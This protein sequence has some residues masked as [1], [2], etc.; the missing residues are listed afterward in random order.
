MEIKRLSP[1]NQK[2]HELSSVWPAQLLNK[3]EPLQVLGY[4]GR[5][6]VV[7]ARK[8]TGEI[9]AV[10]IPYSRRSDVS[11]TVLKKI[12][13][14]EGEVLSSISHRGVVKLIE[15][16]A[17]G[18]YIIIERLSH[19]SLFSKY[20]SKMPTIS[21]GLHYAALLAEALHAVHV[22]GYLHLDFKP[23]N[24]L[25]HDVSA[26][27]PMLVDFGSARHTA[28]PVGRGTVDINK[29]GTGK[30]KF[31]APEQLMYMENVYSAQTDGFGLGVT[32]Y[33]LFC[34]RMPFSNSCAS[35]DRALEIYLKEYH[36]AVKTARAMP[37]PSI[38]KRLVEQLISIDM[39]KRPCNMDRVAGELRRS[40][41]VTQAL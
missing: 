17:D 32:L 15:R 22:A 13:A 27:C 20:S 18:E 5:S 19:V 14:H 24:I 40:A 25:F 8:C 4:G 3:Y 7:E 10:K 29:L 34:G 6:I 11:K 39:N 1:S 9:V 28:K 2:G 31:K 30:Y 37:L 38:A 26:K 23:H 12:L 21:A 36:D 35:Q 41:L 16:E 33:W